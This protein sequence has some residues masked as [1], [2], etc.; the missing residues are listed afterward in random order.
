MDK[1]KDVPPGAIIQV[2]GLSLF[3]R[4]I[5]WY[6][7]WNTGISDLPTHCAIYIGSGKGLV[8]EAGT[9]VKIGK[10]SKYFDSKHKVS[11][12]VYKPMTTEQLQVVK[13]NAYSS[14]GKPY[15]WAAIISFIFKNI[16]ENKYANYCS[17]LVAR[18][19]KWAGINVSNSHWPDNPVNT[20]KISPGD[21]YIYALDN[22]DLWR[23]RRLWTGK[24][25]DK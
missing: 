20:P 5:R 17:E 12:L 9:K 22:N 6:Q 23:I 10:I 16:K 1:L 4:L 15:D 11:Y 18:C 21:I 8:I 24:K 13:S 2:W 3:S 7:K 14:L 19:Y 25:W